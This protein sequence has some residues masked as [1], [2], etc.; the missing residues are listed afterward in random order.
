MDTKIAVILTL[1]VLIPAFRLLVWRKRQKARL[2]TGVVSTRNAIAILGM[3]GYPK[4]IVQEAVRTF[5]Q[6]AE[7]KEGLAAR[8]KRHL[9]SWLG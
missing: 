9:E 8:F 4:P 1:L 7:S 2:Q 3:S 6:L 5:E